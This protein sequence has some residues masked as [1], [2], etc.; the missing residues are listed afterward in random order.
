ML[1]EDLIW[2]AGYGSNLDKER[3]Y[4]YIRGGRPKGNIRKNDG[5][6]DNSLPLS[7]KKMLI[8]YELYFS[9]KSESWNGGGVA[10][11]HPQK[12]D[13]QLTYAHLY[14]ITREQFCDIAMQEN[15]LDMIPEIPFDIII[16]LG[17]HT[18]P[19]V[20]AYNHLLFLGKED[21][22]PV[23]TFTH[24]RCFENTSQPSR[25]YLA[26]IARGLKAHFKLTDKLVCNY[27]LNKE[28]ISGNYSREELEEL[29]EL[30]FD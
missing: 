26:A 22:L 25:S 11:I 14:L 28:G 20:K 24:Y 9:G 1:K 29:V 5:C 16:N 6:R 8:P 12:D 23:F 2:Y 27:L 18:F 30:A 3:F 19:K 4:C 7:E 13:T 21:D 15:D 10:Y 17:Q